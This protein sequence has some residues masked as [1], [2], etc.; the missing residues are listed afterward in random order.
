MRHDRSATICCKR[1]IHFLQELRAKAK[2][3]KF[4]YHLPNL[5]PFQPYVVA[6]QFQPYIVPYSFPQSK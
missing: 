2:L 5:A 3:Q 6:N 4:M 1:I